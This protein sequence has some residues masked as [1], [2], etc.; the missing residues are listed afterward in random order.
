MQ[1]ADELNMLPQDMVSEQCVLGSCM[2]SASAMDDVATILSAE[3]FFAEKHQLLWMTLVDMRERG[4]PVDAV[5]LA[6]ALDKKKQLADVGGVVY[7]AEVLASVPHSA[8]AMHYAENVIEKSRRRAA[9]A[10]ADGIQRAARDQSR[11]VDDALAQAESDIHRAIEMGIIQADI[12][13][14]SALMS[15]LDSLGKERAA[16]LEIQ[17]PSVDKI[18]GGLAKGTVT[19]LA[20]RP[21]VGKTAF[22]M[23]TLRRMG[24][25][26]IPTALFSYEMTREQIAERT[27]AA[28]TGISLYDLKRGNLTSAQKQDLVHQA[29]IASRLPIVIDDTDRT[30][31]QLL[32]TMRTTVRKHKVQVV[33]IDYLQ[34][35]PSGTNF[36]IREQEIAH[37]SRTLKRAAKSLGIN[38]ILLSQLNRSVDLR[39]NQR[40]KLSDLRESGAIE[41]DADQ[42]LFLWRPNKDQQGVEGKE[43]CVDDHGFMTIAKNRQGQLGEAKLYWNG[44]TMTYREWTETSYA[45]PDIDFDDPE[46]SPKEAKSW[47]N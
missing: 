32:S 37:I 30:L 44:P 21:S 46:P 25:C 4:K 20:A 8:H 39:D 1:N 12:S 34:I 19:V 38:I 13:I 22:V 47:R 9:I 16:G 27:L 31:P 26:G 40:P 35:V 33:A 10:A 7:I 17:I 2:L 28:A 43:N 24:E 36:K 6:T 42:V 45:S 5:T 41:Q 23:T 3:H 18:L 29:Q 11:S 15:A 14:E